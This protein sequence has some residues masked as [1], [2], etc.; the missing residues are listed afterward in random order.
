MKKAFKI[1]GVIF[2]ILALLIIAVA[3][4]LPIFITPNDLKPIISKQVYKATGRELSFQSDI[5]WTFFPSIGIELGK[6]TLNNAKGFNDTPFAVLNQ[7][8]VSVQLL[9][10]LTKQIKMNTLV[11]D[12]LTINIMKNR[13]G[14]KTNIPSVKNDPASKVKNQKTLK[15]QTNTKK[16]SFHDLYISQL[17]IKDLTITWEDLSSGEKSKISNINLRA[18]NI[19]PKT[20]FPLSLSLDIHSNQPDIKGNISL[21]TKLLL[22]W[23]NESYK[24]SDLILKTNL[25]GSSLPKQQLICLLKTNAALTANIFKIKPINL[26]LNEDTLTGYI[27]ITNINNLTG[28]FSILIDNLNIDDWLT[29]PKKSEQLS[30]TTQPSKTEISSVQPT[31]SAPLTTFLRK[32]NLKGN[33]TIKKLTVMK[34]HAQDAKINLHAQNG[35][36]KL[37]PLT[38]KLYRGNFKGGI[39]LNAQ[40]KTPV[41]S[42]FANLHNIDIKPLLKDL[43]GYKNLI[44]TA[45]LQTNIKTTTLD[46]NH[47]IRNLNGNVQFNLENGAVTGIDIVYLIKQARSLSKKNPPPPRRGSNQT[48]F[49]TLQGTAVINNGIVTNNDLHLLSKGIEVHGKG[50]ANL[51][52]QRLDYNIT[53][54]DP[55][56][57]SEWL[58]P[59]K[60]TGTFQHP[61]QHIE[62]E[63]ILKNVVKQQIQEQIDN[64]LKK[65]KIGSLLH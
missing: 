64:Q 18:S 54:S 24:L 61:K 60:I 42:Q 65:L 46:P 16:T 36:I 15:Q 53:A 1:I 3:I 38:A 21:K 23:Q 5:S 14:T 44:G 39:N 10:L 50:T 11:V 37:S 62:I 41:I 25:H 29:N 58:V 57:D 2:G 17:N 6:V 35:I 40:Q 12:G 33:I 47:M 26:K 49:G 51:I 13:Q 9:P 52:T 27:D 4:L 34:L 45:N 56:V 7:A 55:D 63:K 30:K 43:A 20:S 31:T 8:K 22:N 48:N 32:L 19:N 59:I 28:G